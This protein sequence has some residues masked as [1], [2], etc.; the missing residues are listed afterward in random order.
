MWDKEYGGYYTLT[1]REG[2]VVSMDGSSN[3]K[4]AYG[5]AFA[6][7]GL[8]AYFEVTGDSSALEQSIEEKN[9]EIA[10][11]QEQLVAAEAAAQQGRV[12]Q[13][14][15][16]DE[17]RRVKIDARHGKAKLVELDEALV[18]HLELAEDE[19]ED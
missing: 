16:L 19:D 12:K 7:Y 13:T 1:D 6:I 8:A 3:T 4:I 10:A 15:V 2:R 14:L 5:N 18:E 17:R 11:L 9:R